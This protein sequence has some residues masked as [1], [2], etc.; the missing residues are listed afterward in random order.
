MKMISRDPLL[1]DIVHLVIRDEARHVTFGVNYLEEFVK[2]LSDQ[3]K[4]ERALFAYEACV[5][6]RERL[7]ATDVFEHFG[8]DVEASRQQVLQAEVME[9]FMP[10]IW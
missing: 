10:L 4:E 8:W 9:K 7:V 2:T 6:M 1:K 3:E 5:V